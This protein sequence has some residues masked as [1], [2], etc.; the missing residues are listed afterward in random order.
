[1]LT[2]MDF[3]TSGR[4]VNHSASAQLCSTACAFALPAVAFSCT[5]WNWS[6]ISSVFFSASAA[7]VPTAASSSRL[8]SGLML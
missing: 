3:G 4:E 8:T 6:N 2:V 7:V 5:S 1:M